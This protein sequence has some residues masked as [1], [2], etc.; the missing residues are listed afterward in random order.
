MCC[1][2]TSRPRQHRARADSRRLAQR[3]GA[4]GSCSPSP[5]GTTA[6]CRP[7]Q[8]ACLPG[9]AWLSIELKLQPHSA[10]S[11]SPLAVA[12][13]TRQPLHRHSLSP[14]RRWWPTSVPNVSDPPGLPPA[15]QVEDPNSGFKIHASYHIPTDGDSW[16][17]SFLGVFFWSM[18]HLARKCHGNSYSRARSSVLVGS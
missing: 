15:W 17:C 8:L 7:E 12:R 5:K 4:T 3:L 18:I 11:L 14:G 9:S 6:R 1:C 10:R 13:G 2:R 16:I